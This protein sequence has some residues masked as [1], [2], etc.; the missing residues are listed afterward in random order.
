M[1]E[2]LVVVLELSSAV[3]WV[4]VMAV[5]MVDS[6]VDVMVDLCLWEVGRSLKVKEVRYIMRI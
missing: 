5:E 2:R 3:L 6:M 4:D 1:V